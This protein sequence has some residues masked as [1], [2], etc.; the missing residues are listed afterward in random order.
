MNVPRV[1]SG[2][3][4]PTLLRGGNRVKWCGAW[5]LVEIGDADAG[6]YVAVS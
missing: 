1:S 2:L 4:D 6:R 5:A 3:P